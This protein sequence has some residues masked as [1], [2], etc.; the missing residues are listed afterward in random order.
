MENGWEIKEIFNLTDQSVERKLAI[1]DKLFKSCILNI[2]G[3]PPD[4]PAWSHWWRS[5]LRGARPFFKDN[6]EIK[7]SIVDLFSGCGGLALGVKEALRA[8]GIEALIKA[9]VDVDPDAVSIYNNN[10]HPEKILCADAKTLV[11]YQI[12][13]WGKSAKF[14]YNPEIINSFLLKLKDKIDIL[15]AGPP[16]EGHSNLNNRTRREDPRNLLYIDTI[17][18]AVA[19]NTKSLIIENVP[20]IVHD[21]KNILDSAISLL[22]REG[23]CT[24]FNT[25]SADELGLAQRRKRSFLIG[26]KIGFEPLSKISN[27]FGMRGPSTLAWAIEDLIDKRENAMDEPSKLSKENER[28]IAWLFENDA[29]NLPNHMRPR[30]HKE[31]HTYPSVYGRMRWDAPAGTISSGFLSPGRGRYIHPLRQR[32]ITPRE[33]AR[34]QGFP[35]WFVFKTSEGYISREKLAKWIGDA[36]PPILG[37]SIAF[38]VIPALIKEKIC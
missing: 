8:S 35:D 5:W 26:S 37:Y 3:L 11:E 6:A 13:D 14:T 22:K 29:Y 17:A 19:L 18:L 38:S 7:V 10:L 21:R 30:C 12:S 1:C 23:Y 9:A 2:S 15:I 24:D 34:I 33:A 16:C 36:V 31:G 28:R 4:K 27:I 25:L 20:S 32:T